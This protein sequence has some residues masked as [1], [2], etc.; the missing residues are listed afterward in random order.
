MTGAGFTGDWARLEVGYR[1]P[2]QAQ[3][4]AQEFARR[5]L[6]KDMID[7]PDADQLDMGFEPCTLKWIQCDPE[8]AERQCVNST[9]AMMRETGKAGLANADITFLC[10]EIALGRKVV[11]SLDSYSG[12]N[13]VHTFETRKV[14]QTRSKM[15]FFMGDARV[16]ATTLHSFKGWEARLLV[17]H[18]G[19]A[20]GSDGFASIYAALTRLKRSPE[21]SW[22]TVVCSAPELSEYGKTWVQHQDE[23]KMEVLSEDPFPWV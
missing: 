22:L 11:R 4:A 1:L 17:V 19:H 2:L 3:N 16:K 13:T 9:L 21:G 7:L 6:P 15:G 23:S 20:I 18:I 10:N 12:V 5:F 8:N 14:D